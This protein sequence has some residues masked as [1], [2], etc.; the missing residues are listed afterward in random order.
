M[1]VF[2]LMVGVDVL[3]SFKEGANGGASIGFPDQAA[4]LQGVETPMEFN[5][6][7]LFEPFLLGIT[8]DRNL[9]DLTIFCYSIRVYSKGNDR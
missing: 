6:M 4:V 5:P 9:T 3:I 7:V 8:R 1:V 2:D